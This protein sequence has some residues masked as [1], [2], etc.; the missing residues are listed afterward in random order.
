MDPGRNA[1][2]IPETIRDAPATLRDAPATLLRASSC[3]SSSVRCRRHRPLAGGIP[4]PAEAEESR[5]PLPPALARGQA[6]AL[7]EGLAVPVLSFVQV[8][9]A[10]SSRLTRGSSCVKRSPSFPYC[11]GKKRGQEG[12]TYQRGHVPDT[13][14]SQVSTQAG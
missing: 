5:H 12:A 9:A 13:L 10:E 8:H 4:R 6:A 7:L 14:T 2:A 3:S 1:E 11:F